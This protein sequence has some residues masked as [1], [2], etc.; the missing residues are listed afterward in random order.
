MLVVLKEIPSIGLD[1]ISYC[2]ILSFETIVIKIDTL[3]T[4]AQNL[5]KKTLVYV[6]EPILPFMLACCL[7]CA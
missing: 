3:G 2:N 5:T 4:M 7:N 6:M 1:T